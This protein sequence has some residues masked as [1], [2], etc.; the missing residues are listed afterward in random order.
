MQSIYDYSV[1]LPNGKDVI[2]LSNYKD[3]YILVVNVASKCKFNAQLFELQNLYSKFKDNLMVIGIPCNQF[4]KQEPLPNDKIIDTYK[5]VFGIEFILSEVST[6]NGRNE[7][8]LYTYLKNKK[9]GL[10]GT[11]GIKWNFEKFLIDKNGEVIGRYST[12]VTPKTISKKLEEII[13]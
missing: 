3:K 10:L 5:S 9:K 7:L 2:P 11:K 4:G 6:V 8:P 12:N 13:S 1:T